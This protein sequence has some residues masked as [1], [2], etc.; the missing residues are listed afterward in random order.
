MAES[1]RENTALH[2]KAYN[3]ADMLADW[4][5]VMCIVMSPE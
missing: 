3:C 5:S 2:R 4:Y 1:S